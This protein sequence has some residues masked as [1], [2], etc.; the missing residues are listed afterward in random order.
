[1]HKVLMRSILMIILV[2]GISNV[3]GQKN[4]LDQPYF[5]TSSQADTFV[6]PDKIT[7]RIIINEAD[8]KNKKSLEE[9]ERSLE[10]VLKKLN[11]DIEK[12]LSVSDLA[13]NFRN[14]F[15][16][17]QNIVKLKSYQ[18]IVHD[19]VTAGK[20]LRE[21]EQGGIS[22]VNIE[23]TEYSKADEIQTILKSIAIKKARAEAEVLASAIHQKLGKALYISDINTAFPVQDKMTRIVI[24]G[25]TSIQADS[26]PE[27]IQAEFEKLKFQVL[28]NVK[29]ALE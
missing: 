17:G 10:N 26:V 28:I 25:Q 19:A 18:L 29:F 20:V 5:E 7:I 9:Q 1:M 12:D 16:R 3:F 21:L 14:Y 8:S 2:A 23:K 22:N 6:I 11:I 13:S 27:P 4:F 15:L 24:R